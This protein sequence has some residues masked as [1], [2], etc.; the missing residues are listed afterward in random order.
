VTADDDERAAEIVG[1]CRERIERGER[2]DV[3]AI[4]REHPDLAPRLARWLG[5]LGVLDQAYAHG[6]GARPS[7]AG[8]RIGAYRIVRELGS[9]GMGTVYL[10]TAESGADGLAAGDRV[11]V[12]LLHEHLCAR[13]GFL[14][15]FLREAEIGRRVR[16]A[17]VVR[18]LDAGETEAGD[19]RLPYLVMEYVEGR[20]LRAL[21]A[22]LG[23]VPEGLCRHV[24]REIAHAL[25]AIHAEGAVHRDLKP[26]NVLITQD[27]V[28]KVMDLGVARVRDEVM[29]L[30]QTGAFVGSL[31]YGA[32]EQ[33]GLACAN[34]AGEPIPRSS[35]GAEGD[36]VD[37]R[38]D[39][40]ALGLTLYELAT[41][42]HP[43]DGDDVRVVVRRL[44]DERPRR[45]GDVNPQLSAL[46][47]EL[48]AQL[49]EKDRD[50]RPPDAA[51]VAR[52]LEEGEESA[53]WKERSQ[54]L[55]RESRRPLRRIRIPRETELYGRE[56]ELANL[57]ALFERAKTGD[58]RVVLLEGE[59]GIGKSRLVDEFVGQLAQAG[60]DVDF[61]FGS[62]PP[63][64]A[65]T[66]SGAF[67]TA[68]RERLG[69]DE[70]A[71][72]AALPQ[73]PLLVPSF[74]ALLRGDPA[75][76]GAVALTK[77]SLQTAFV[78]A[79]RTLASQRTTIVLIDDLHFAPQ[80][81]RAL[82]AALAL[83]V[84]GHRILLVGCARPSLDEEW[85][86]QLATRS[87]STRLTLTRLGPKELVHLLRDALRS[88][89]L[90]EELSALIAVKSDGNPFFVFELLQ[91]LRDG[92]FLRQK[93]DGTWETTQIIRDIQVPSSIAE[94]VQARVAD[95]RAEDKDLL[96]VASCCG[97][98]FDPLVVAQAL[99][100]DRV[101][102]LQALGRIE[103]RHRLV[104]AAGRRFVFDH[105]QVQEALYAGLSELLLEEYHARLGDA[106]EASAGASSKD[107]G[108]VPGTT[109]V[110]LAEHLLK[111]AQGA[112]A[113]RYLDAAMTH[114][115]KNY[116]NDAAVRVAD[117]AL[118]AP[119]L[120]AGTER[121]EM[122]LRK[123]GRLDVLGRREAER[124]AL[125]EAAALAET[126]GDA[127]L[128]ARTSHAQGV[129]YYRLADHA[130][131]RSHHERALALAKE[132]GN[133][134]LEGRAT[135]NLGNVARGLGSNDD[136][137]SHYARALA[138]ATGLADRE[139]E[140]KATLNLGLTSYD[141]GRFDEARSRN[142]R[143]LALAREIG[144]RGLESRA[145]GNLGN[146]L[147]AFGL[148]EE[149]LSNCERDL[150]I[151]REIGD[152]P[153]EAAA[154][155]NL[156]NS[157]YFLGRYA[158][159]RASYERQLELVREIGDRGGEAL[160]MS[161]LGLM[162]LE[163]GDRHRAR[164]LYS[165]SRALSRRVGSHHVEADALRGLGEV[166]D[167]DDDVAAAA[168]LYEESIALRVAA[169]SRV[170]LSETSML[171]GALRCRTGDVTGGRG[172]VEDAVALSRE[173]GSAANLAFGLSILACLPGGDAAAAVAALAD[174]GSGAD[175]PR[176]RSQLWR[177][178]GDTAHLA[179]AK[180][181][182]D[183]LVAHAP[184]ECRESM[185]A[186]VRLH[187]EIV[188][189]ARE[190]GLA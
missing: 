164:E 59:A 66:A 13:P 41:G 65:A 58:G 124:A 78:Q 69:E 119:G 103:K 33:F 89:R 139:L 93:P 122:L 185:L 155:G 183:H 53:W 133:A 60:E 27:H 114:L 97:F 84:P 77:D 39:L 62:Y 112:R 181:L 96:D 44:I 116:L 8:Q 123:A 165:E 80:E 107:A 29:H 171:L 173:E 169:G 76:A 152:R 138:L 125:E 43:F 55:R 190:H 161:N 110:E 64:G 113:L 150:A 156:G 127:V 70:A 172:T 170:G 146:A 68:Y 6:A 28:V 188:A 81:G 73:A 92:Q 22:E 46:F 158:L 98:E 50:L 94:L 126:S 52:V 106:I 82:F 23:R 186:N 115:E 105:H 120:L 87:Q 111:G 83:A 51:H 187:R 11:A 17:N 128:R 101:A 142:E 34:G 117:R 130:Q 180:R 95:L 162:W 57:R 148:H 141:L 160:A 9:G 143:A 168:H 147:N 1:A 140:A 132:T 174:G 56:G 108:D 134:R 32:P 12:K 184:P 144:A 163:L 26:D 19:G 99:R 42:V 71:I 24:G 72:G 5:G 85:V 153:D 90:A 102:V 154:T 75:P 167:A 31:R 16:H 176:T 109:C 21:L 47:E 100:R 48:V 7:R 37:H 40:H 182:L 25:A 104:R 15:R 88:E 3:V 67:S 74:A 10:A 177:A 175:T 91:G 38:V 179:V 189:A 49:L 121:C 149:A 151:S 18:T 118:A 135:L 129:H 178:T 14:Q 145:S 35:A 36:T 63:G 137:R 45:A 136:A 79:T 166:A 54:A 2:V 86:G 61:L 20:T 4:V 30:S 157:F 159:A 131:A